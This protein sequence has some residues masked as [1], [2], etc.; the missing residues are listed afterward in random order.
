MKNIYAPLKQS[1]CEGI[2]TICLC[3]AMVLGGGVCYAQTPS[4]ALMMK[5]RETCIAI[6][7]D[8]GSWD[9]YWEGT[10]LRSNETVA[11]LTRQMVMPM[12]AIGIHDRLNLI[13]G[14]PFV[15]TESNEPNGGFFAGS[16]GFQDLVIALKGHVIQKQLGKGTLNFLATAGF[17]TPMTNYLSDYGPYA[18]GF[19]AT[20]WNLRGILEYRLDNGFYV[21]S[22]LAHLWRGVTEAERDY[23]YNNG[24]YYTSVMDVPNAWNY[25]V[26][27]GMWFLDNT[28]KLE[29]AYTSLQSTSGDD[30]RKYNAGQPTNNVQFGQVEASAQY[31]FTGKLSGFGLLTRYAQIIHGRNMGKFTTLGAGITYLFKI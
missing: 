24:S 31:Y 16:Q 6:M 9:Q 14:T 2:L 20:E 21:R 17:S 8:H 12:V 10:H 22:S 25:Q 27:A 15:K 11:T 19:G 23:Y 26:V 3:T 1:L 13:V 18:L 7:Y 30:I 5:Q 29:T 28:L 4:D